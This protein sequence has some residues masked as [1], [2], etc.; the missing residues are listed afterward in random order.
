MVAFQQAGKPA[1]RFSARSNVVFAALK[2]SGC[3]TEMVA[4]V[5]TASD[6]LRFGWMQ[7]N[8]E[9]DGVPIPSAQSVKPLTTDAL[10]PGVRFAGL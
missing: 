7:L 5:S 4:L 8:G 2:G 1:T 6:Y 3:G 9:I 10:S